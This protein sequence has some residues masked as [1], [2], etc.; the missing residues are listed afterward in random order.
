MLI[1]HTQK[2]P[3]PLDSLHLFSTRLTSTRLT[4][5]RLAPPRALP[6]FRRAR[7]LALQ[8]MGEETERVILG[9]EHTRLE[10]EQPVPFCYLRSLV[11]EFAL[12]DFLGFS[13]G[14]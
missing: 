8:T 7:P 13:P 3:S 5:S 11:L 12:A 14:P 4:S 6:R 1:H 10:P 2:G 9:R